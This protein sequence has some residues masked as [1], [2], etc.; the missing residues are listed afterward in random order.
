MR[1][2]NA[3]FICFKNHLRRSFFLFYLHTCIHT[4]TV[5]ITMEIPVLHCFSRVLLASLRSGHRF[6]FT[7]FN[8]CIT[9]LVMKQESHKHPPQ[10][11][12]PHL[13]YLIYTF[14]LISR[15]LGSLS[16][17]CVGRRGVVSESII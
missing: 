11:P 17:H 15:L 6:F 10:K 13:Q 8:F 9:R 7:L 12:Q 1:N 3:K 5:Q 14:E 16:C 2:P 4:H